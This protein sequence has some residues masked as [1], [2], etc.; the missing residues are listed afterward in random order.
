MHFRAAMGNGT[1]NNRCEMWM[2]IG[3]R[4]N[5]KRDDDDGGGILS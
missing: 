5:E 1:M 3:V 2:R 4:K